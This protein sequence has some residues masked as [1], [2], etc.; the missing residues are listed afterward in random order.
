MAQT[1]SP[2]TRCSKRWFSAAVPLMPMRADELALAASV[3]QNEEAATPGSVAAASIE[4]LRDITWRHGRDRAHAAG[5]MAGLDML[6]RI[7]ENFSN[8][9]LLSVARVDPLQQPS[10]ERKAAEPLPRRF[11]FPGSN[12]DALLHQQRH[13]SYAA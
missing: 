10:R 7:P 1:G 4:Q 6:G 3:S 8:R 13:L 2:A 5:L 12:E 11:S 9:N